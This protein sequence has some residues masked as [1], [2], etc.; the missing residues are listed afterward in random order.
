MVQC[1]KFVM[2]LGSKINSRSDED[3]W[4]FFPPRNFDYIQHFHRGIAWQTATVRTEDWFTDYELKEVIRGQRFGSWKNV[5]F[6]RTIPSPMDLSRQIAK[7]IWPQ[8]KI[9]SQVLFFGGLG[10]YSRRFIPTDDTLEGEA[11]FI[12]VSFASV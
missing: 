3:D 8:T 9:G 7:Q 10:F 4:V 1:H 2:V 6:Q 11:K 5:R 12:L